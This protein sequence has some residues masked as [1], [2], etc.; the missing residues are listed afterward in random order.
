MMPVKKTMN[1]WLF[2]AGMVFMVVAFGIINAG[3]VSVTEN[4]QRQHNIAN[5]KVSDLKNTKQ[6]LEEELDTIDTDAF[7]ERQARDEYD[8]MMPDELRFVITFPDEE[9][10][11]PS[12]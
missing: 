12:L 1:L 8:Y 10:E 3:I 2:I 4:I 6:E 7:V 9:T 5:K 11:E